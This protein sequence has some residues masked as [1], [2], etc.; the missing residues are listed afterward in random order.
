[1]EVSKIRH[2]LAIVSVK[3]RYIFLGILQVVRFEV[4]EVLVVFV[5][6]GGGMLIISD[7]ESGEVWFEPP[8]FHLLIFNSEK[9]RQSNIYSYAYGKKLLRGGG[10]FKGSLVGSV[11]LKPLD[12]DLI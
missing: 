9:N 2:L 3:W 11:L 6:V 8:L 10:R 12:S 5:N 4:W 1:M 7:S